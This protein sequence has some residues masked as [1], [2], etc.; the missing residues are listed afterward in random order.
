MYASSD[1]RAVADSISNCI[2]CAVP[3]RWTKSLSHFLQRLR[4]HFLKRL[5]VE[6]S[7]RA[8]GEESDS[9]AEEEEGPDAADDFDQVC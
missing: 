4:K 8:T 1:C 7:P 5:R 3:C 6:S 2:V 9:D